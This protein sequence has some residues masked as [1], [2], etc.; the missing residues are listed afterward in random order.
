MPNWRRYYYIKTNSKISAV[1]GEKYA[2][3]KKK[4]NHT[5]NILLRIAKKTQPC[6]KNIF[7]ILVSL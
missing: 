6:F 3:R 2:Q 4:K 7:K 5:W 1:A